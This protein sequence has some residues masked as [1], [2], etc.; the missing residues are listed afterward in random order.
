MVWCWRTFS[1]FINCSSEVDA[2]Q[3]IITVDVYRKTIIFVT[4]RFITS[5]KLNFSHPP[6]AKKDKSTNCIKSIRILM[7][8]LI[9]CFGSFTTSSYNSYESRVR[10]SVRW[11]QCL[12]SSSPFTWKLEPRHFCHSRLKM[13]AVKSISELSF[14]SYFIIYTVL[15]Y[16]GSCLESTMTQS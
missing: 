13:S 7:S 2:C 14:K 8:S 16:T 5:L 15:Q 6:R 11:G 9:E 10:T 3:L 4:I 12:T 1:L